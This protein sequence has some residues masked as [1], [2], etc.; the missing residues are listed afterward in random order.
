MKIYEERELFY[1]WD[2][3]QKITGNFSVGEE[4]HFSNGR[5]IGAYVVMTY[6]LD[7]VVVAD[8]PNIL[9]Q[10]AYPIVAH[11]F[12]WDG[13][14]GYTLE[15][16]TF[17]VKP[18]QKP[19]DYAYTE[20]EV[21]TWKTL[22]EKMAE[23][24][25][26]L[27]RQAGLEKGTGENATQKTGSHGIAKDTT[28]L[29]TNCVAGCLGYYY[30]AIDIPR[31]HIYLST[32]QVV[33]ILNASAFS[34]VTDGAFDTYCSYPFREDESLYGFTVSAFKE[35]KDGGYID[36][37]SVTIGTKENWTD[38]F[39]TDF[40]TSSDL[41]A[42][43]A[44]DSGITWQDGYIRI[45]R[46]STAATTL[47]YALTKPQKT[48]KVTFRLRVRTNTYN[49]AIGICSENFASKIVV[50]TNFGGSLYVRN[51]SYILANNFADE[52]WHEVKIVADMDART[53]SAWADQ[54]QIDVSGFYDPSFEAPTYAIGDTFSLVNGS[55]YDYVATIASIDGNRI[56]YD[57][58]IGFKSISAVLAD[59][60][61]DDY[62]FTV[63][64]N[65]LV[66]VIPFG[67]GAFASGENAIA[68]N[69]SSFSAGRNTKALGDYAAA[70][71]RDVIALYC[72][73]GFGKDILSRAMYG[74][75]GGSKSESL[76][77]AIASITYGLGLINPTA[78]SA[79]FG[80][81]NDYSKEYLLSLGNGKS[82]TERSNAY[83]VDFDG[84][85]WYSGSVE[86]KEVI[87]RSSI[88]GS[89]KRFKIT[90]DDS[91][92]IT[93]IPIT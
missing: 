42:F 52:E 93:A 31:K 63:P 69:R 21:L 67:E 35:A 91:G 75:V 92:T 70:I 1:Q 16:K 32:K 82:D 12:K 25:A 73:L 47:G 19:H 2:I 49:I 66:G 44:K 4:I 23:N 8:V 39:H 87:V 3:N 53:V 60:D 76:R 7:G 88:E 41:D 26:E 20:T 83:T 13:D 57:G 78:Y 62:A 58:E 48:G 80:Q 40:L 29:G 56:T 84:N 50:G 43:Q 18:R 6:E 46:R 14:S 61:H 74:V 37:D 89:T 38:I 86:G 54:K 33:P 79:L 90:V 68:S 34:G 51:S 28:A 30:S 11:R 15:E 17:K 65:P 45:P 72:A 81:Y 22:E 27:F 71:G 55:H 36:L 24:L 59:L 64:E 5:P 77:E 9:L 10:N 85:A